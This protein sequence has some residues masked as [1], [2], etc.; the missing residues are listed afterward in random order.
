MQIDKEHENDRDRFMAYLLHITQGEK[1][2]SGVRL[3]PHNFCCSKLRGPVLSLT[4]K[5]ARP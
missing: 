3:L 4:R 5:G 1:K 2:I